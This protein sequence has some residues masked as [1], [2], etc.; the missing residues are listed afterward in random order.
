MLNDATEVNKGP[1]VKMREKNI[2]EFIYKDNH[3]NIIEIKMR[4][5]GE[6]KGGLEE[7]KKK[8][9]VFRV[10]LGCMLR[11]IK[12]IRFVYGQQ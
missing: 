11:Y 9:S 3:R 5:V 2:V 8:L 4:T 1:R 12:M 6:K 10:N 7:E